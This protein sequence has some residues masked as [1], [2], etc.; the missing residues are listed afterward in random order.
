MFIIWLS[1]LRVF[2][3]VLKNKNEKQLFPWGDKTQVAIPHPLSF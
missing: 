3:F 1:V 2:K